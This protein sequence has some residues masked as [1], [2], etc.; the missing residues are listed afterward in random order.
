MP[1]AANFT[2]IADSWTAHA[3]IDFEIPSTIDVQS[4]PVLTFMLDPEGDTDLELHVLVNGQ[5]VW[6]WRFRPD[7]SRVARL[8]QEVLPSGLVVPGPNR[9]ELSHNKSTSEPILVSDVVLWWQA[10]L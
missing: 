8:Y 3:R 4:R 6:R 9:M 5:S 10:N 1:R 7:A 2:V